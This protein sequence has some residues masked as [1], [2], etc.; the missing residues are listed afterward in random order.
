MGTFS[1]AL[2]RA[3]HLVFR[4]RLKLPRGL[5]LGLMGLKYVL[6]AYFLF[7]VFLQMTLA[8]VALFIDSPYNRIA[9]IKMLHFFTRLSL[10][11]AWVLGAGPAVVRGAVL[12][13]PLPLPVR[14]AARRAVLAVP[15]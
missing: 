2:A 4:R 8:S 1:E 5:D 10:T 9:D 13:V 6:L 7:A 15:G 12:L 3:S 11:A 14:R